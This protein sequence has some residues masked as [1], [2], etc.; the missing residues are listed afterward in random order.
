M[1]VGD[2]VGGS[3]EVN[4]FSRPVVVVGER[5]RQ[6]TD[7]QLVRAAEVKETVLTVDVVERRETCYL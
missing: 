4:F 7:S 3:S 2:E 5:G 1:V 6:S